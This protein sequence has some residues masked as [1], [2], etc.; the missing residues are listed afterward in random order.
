MKERA[1]REERESPRRGLLL[2][3]LLII[4][5][6]ILCMF[7]AGQTAIRLD[8]S[9][10]ANADMGSNQDPNAGF[11][12][13]TT[14]ELMGPISSDILTQPV[15]ADLFL[16]PGAIIPTRII[17]T[18]PP[19]SLPQPTAQPTVAIP[20]DIPTLIPT[21]I[22]TYIPPPTF[23]P[24]PKPTNPPPPP[25]PPPPPS[26]DLSITVTDNATDYEAGG[27]TTYEIIVSN[28]S[29]SNIT[30]ATITDNFPGQLTN[31][32]WTCVPTGAGA[33]CTAGPVN[34]NISD[35]VNLP[36]GTFVT[37]TVVADVIAA[38]VG[39]LVNNA[40]VT[41]PT[42]FVDSNGSNNSRTDTSALIVPDPLPGQIGVAPD[43]IYYTLPAGGTLTLELATPLDVPSTPAYDLVYYE[44]PS[45]PAPQGIL[46]DWVQIQIGDGHNWY[47]IF[48]WG[49]EVADT[50]TNVDFN[51]LPDPP[52]GWPPFP[53]PTGTEYEGDQR[54]I[55]ATELYNNSGVVIDL[56]PVV[57]AGTYPYIRFTAPTG[58]SDGQLEIDAIAICPAGGCIW[59]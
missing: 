23:P 8:P 19:T 37:Y 3:I 6:G 2:L 38:P 57:P 47:T 39:D 52:A 24:P 51:I 31:I 14:P 25:P 12:V 59:P 22:P 28:L 9:W 32:S 1:E 34:G 16:T 4:L 35:I 54:V 13:D 27:T 10:T 36:V 29:G 55:L 46:L 5:L 53:P 30:G 50:N 40:T 45:G 48:Y 21:L 56:D 11:D 18:N 43:T 17:P 15:W 33:S 20:T 49:D 42:G 58:D 26:A 41:V 44:Y 7:V